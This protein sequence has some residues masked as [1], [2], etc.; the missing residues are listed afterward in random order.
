MRTFLKTAVLAIAVMLTVSTGSLL[1]Q[2]NS[3]WKKV[4]IADVPSKVMT[5]YH[6]LFAHD[7]IMK[8][9][10]AGTGA[11]AQY[12]LTIKRKGKPQEVIFDAKGRAQ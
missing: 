11:A 8:A 5:G 10:T 12:R 6:K 4:A 2:G 7:R 1:A 9:E 3:Q